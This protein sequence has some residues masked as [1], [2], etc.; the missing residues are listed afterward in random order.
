M[1][2][3]VSYIRRQFPGTPSIDTD[4]AKE[5]IDTKQTLIIDCRREDEFQVSKIPGAK[6]LDFKCEDNELTELLKD[7][8]KD[9]QIINYCSLGYRSAIMT[10]RIQNLVKDR[11]PVYN[12]E[13]SIFKW[14]NE[15]KPLTDHQDQ[16]TLKVHPY[17][18]KF[19]F[20]TLSWNRWKWSKDD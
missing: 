1:N 5:I 6:N 10:N 12:L 20:L 15:N 13:G 3:I 14:A 19:A 18:F 2:F 17:S 9:T 11:N 8:E 7:V 4:Q 16:P